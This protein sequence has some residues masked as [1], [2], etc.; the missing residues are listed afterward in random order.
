MAQRFR[1]CLLVSALFACAFLAYAQSTERAPFSRDPR[2][3]DAHYVGHR[4]MLGPDWL[5][6]A[7]DNPAYASP[8]YD[9]SA[10]QTVSANRTLASYGI[11]DLPH[12]W[13]RIHVHLPPRARTAGALGVTAFRRCV[14]G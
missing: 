13:Y 1:L 12:A 10:W 7:S 14:V 9:D 6:S 3:F 11:G 5:F 2:N 4:A 8:A